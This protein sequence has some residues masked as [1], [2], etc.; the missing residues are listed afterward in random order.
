MTLIKKK[1]N[2]FAVNNNN[3]KASGKFYDLQLKQQLQVFLSG[4]LLQTI[5]IQICFSLAILI[6]KNNL[7]LSIKELNNLF[8]SLLIISNV[9]LFNIFSLHKCLQIIFNISKFQYLQLNKNYFSS[10][11]ND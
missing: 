1:Q 8:I 7:I 9:T 4:L 5:T 10:I 6:Y 2:S 11:N 3:A